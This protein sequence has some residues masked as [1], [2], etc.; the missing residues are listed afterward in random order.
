MLSPERELRRITQQQIDA[1]GRIGP[2]FG[3]DVHYVD[4]LASPQPRY[5][6]SFSGIRYRSPQRLTTQSVT[7]VAPYA[8]ALS[9]RGTP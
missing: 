1:F 5:S 3:F 6:H 9:R 4:H 7:N 8:A 2:R